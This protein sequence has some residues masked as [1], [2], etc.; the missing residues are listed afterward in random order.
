[1]VSVGRN[2]GGRVSRLRL[3]G[4]NNFSGLWG[5][6]AVPSCPAPGLRLIMAGG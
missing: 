3:A 6:G 4:L 5:T 1:M 2:G